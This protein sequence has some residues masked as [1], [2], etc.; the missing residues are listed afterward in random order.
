MLQLFVI[1][2]LKA[3]GAYFVQHKVQEAM[4]LDRPAL[5]KKLRV[6]LSELAGRVAGR[7]KDDVTEALVIVM[8]FCLVSLIFR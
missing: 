4:V 8:H 7:N 1:C 2:L 3:V 5:T 6:L